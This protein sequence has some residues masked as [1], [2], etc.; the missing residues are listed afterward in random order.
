[1]NGRNEI[2]SGGTEGL[3][4]LQSKVAQMIA[5]AGHTMNIDDFVHENGKLN[6]Q[7]NECLE[8]WETFPVCRYIIN[9]LCNICKYDTDEKTLN[10]LF[11]EIDAE[12]GYS[13]SSESI[14]DYLTNYLLEQIDEISDDELSDELSEVYTYDVIR[15]NLENMEEAFF[16][17]FYAPLLNL[18]PDDIDSYLVRAFKRD[19]LCN[20][21]PNEFLLGLASDI[22]DYFG[23]HSTIE[24]FCKLMK[25]YEE[26]EVTETVKDEK[27]AAE[28]TRYIAEKSME[29]YGTDSTNS[30]TFEVENYEKIAELIQWYKALEKPEERD[31]TELFNAMMKKGYAS[32]DEDMDDYLRILMADKKLRKQESFSIP[33]T[34]WYRSKDGKT[35]YIEKGTE[36]SG[37]K[38]L[39]Y[40]NDRIELTHQEYVT[41]VIHVTPHPDNAKLTPP[42]RKTLPT[43]AVFNVCEGNVEKDGMPVVTNVRTDVI[44]YIDP[45]KNS[46]EWTRPKWVEDEEKS[47]FVVLDVKE[48]E[49]IPKNVCFEYEGFKFLP[50]ADAFEVDT[51]SRKTF[52]IFLDI[53][54]VKMKEL[55]EKEGRTYTLDERNS[56][57]KMKPNLDFISKISNDSERV[58]ILESVLK[59]MKEN[60]V[61]AGADVHKERMVVSTEELFYEFM[62]GDKDYIEVIGRDISKTSKMGIDT[63]NLSWLKDTIISGDAQW[64]SSECSTYKQR[65]IVMVMHYLIYVTDKDKRLMAKNDRPRFV[66]DFRVYI[67]KVME[68]WKFDGLYLGYPIDCLVMFLI[69]SC[70]H[71]DLCDTLRA[72]YKEVNKAK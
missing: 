41:C 5:E 12:E 18:S 35:E 22:Y 42:Q 34:V 15:K 16:I 64:F 50:A 58:V 19:S 33:V 38:C 36:F 61:E 47:S 2:K 49:E 32:V 14:L 23:K 7:L 51:R 56:I 25:Y 11:D 30:V 6:V 52:D 48:G 4:E 55:G 53:D 62:Y 27:L 40:L 70:Q 21:K 9:V 59:D 10:L 8:K 1:M 63:K 39:Y 20:F 44:K 3:K 31:R 26:V 54:S 45:K 67:D 57:T 66:N 69:A 65:A 13:E 28:G 29:D 46:R 37:E 24:I 17:N 72:L 43:G 68:N 71:A 60:K